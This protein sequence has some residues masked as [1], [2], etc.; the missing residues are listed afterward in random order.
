MRAASSAG[1]LRRRGRGM[2][3]SRRAPPRR[4]APSSASR[5]RRSASALLGNIQEWKGQRVVVEAMAKLAAEH[6]TAHCLIVGGVHRAGEE[7]A[8]RAAP[9]LFGAGPRRPGS[10]RRISRGRSGR[11]PRAGR[12]G[13]R[14]GAAG[15]VRARDPGGDAARQAGGGDR[16]RRGNGVDRGR[17]DW[18]PGAAGR[19]RRP[20]A[21]P[22][23]RLLAAPDL[24]RAVGT[25]AR[26]WAR[27][28]FSLSRQVAEMSDIYERAVRN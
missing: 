18:L 11:H 23:H 3:A 26:V 4:C 5:P 24:A 19:R 9:P 16:R 8:R 15:A 27:Q 25:Q 20:G 13:A 14:L 21:V 17:A 1:G 2:A 6:P 22:A 10:L 7:Y 28:Q 12:G